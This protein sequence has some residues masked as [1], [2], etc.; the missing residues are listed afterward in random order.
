[1]V[2]LSEEVSQALK[3]CNGESLSVEAAE[4]S[5]SADDPD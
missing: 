5:I 3:A 2:R 1:M 4:G